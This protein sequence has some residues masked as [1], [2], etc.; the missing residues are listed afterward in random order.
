MG[1]RARPSWWASRN[2]WFAYINGKPVRLA[3]RKEDKKGAYE[4]FHRVQAQGKALAK[5]VAL[6][7]ADAVREYR[8]A[9]DPRREP[10]TN[11]QYDYL[12][13][14]FL[15]DFGR[16]MANTVTGRDLDKWVERHGGANN[17][18]RTNRDRIRAVFNWCVANDLLDKDPCR[19]SVAIARTLK[20]GS[21]LFRDDE[22]QRLFENA[23]PCMVR[24]MTFL[25]HTG[26]RPK[27]AC[28]A[29]GE[30]YDPEKHHLS[31]PKHKTAKKGKARHI[32]L[33]ATAEGMVTQAIAMYGNGILFRDW[34]GKPWTPKQ[35]ADAFRTIRRRAKVRSQVVLYSFRHDLACA[36]LRKNL[37]YARVAN[38]LGNSATVCERHYSHLVAS[39]GDNISAI[40]SLFE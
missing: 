9:T 32:P 12:L 34:S 1:R 39:H 26:C 31:L 16:R 13:R 35:A 2:G 14:S 5:P 19:G 17:S 10:K 6:T 20:D 33:D 25:Q 36:L 4:T 21:I 38:I 37:S 7:V 15:T 24:L 30:M 27:E 40:S 3:D 11:K 23:D 22:E 18:R 29:S 8:E 28:D